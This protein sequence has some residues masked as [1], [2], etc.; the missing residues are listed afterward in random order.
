VV[1][2]YRRAAQ[3]PGA[4]SGGQPLSFGTAA[5]HPADTV[6]RFN[7]R[8]EPADRDRSPI[9]ESH[10]SVVRHN[11][12]MPGTRSRSAACGARSRPCPDA[13][14][15]GA[16]LFAS[17]GEDAGGAG[18]VPAH[19]GQFESLTNDGFAAGFGAAVLG[20]RVLPGVYRYAY[21]GFSWQR[22]EGRFAAQPAS[23]MAASY[24]RHKLAELIVDAGLG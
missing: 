12:M 20:V 24:P 17:E 13:L 2:T 18:D 4:D 9:P 14:E 6:S 11:R 8:T 19:A 21:R 23:R 16:G 15:A 1:I 3:H 7:H 5:F 10:S 22:G